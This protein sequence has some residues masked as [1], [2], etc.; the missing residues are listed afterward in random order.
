MH[1]VTAAAA[2]TAHA[3]ACMQRQYL[4]GINILVLMQ[5]QTQTLR[6]LHV[7]MLRGKKNAN[8]RWNAQ[9]CCE[10]TNHYLAQA[11]PWIPLTAMLFLQPR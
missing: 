11:S 10:N 2:S 6:L 4:I 3:H 9:V 5:T 8:N 1:A 7:H